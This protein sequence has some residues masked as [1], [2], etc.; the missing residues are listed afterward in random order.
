MALGFAA[1]LVFLRP[2]KVGK[3][4]S[5]GSWNS[6]SYPITDNKASWLKEKWEAFDEQH[7]MMWLKDV[8]GHVEIWGED[9]GS[10]DDWVDRV[11]FHLRHILSE[12]VHL[13]S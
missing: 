6:V 12:G 9:L 1:Y 3:T 11:D 2:I 13:G 5:E 8:L 7:S 4:K 10:N